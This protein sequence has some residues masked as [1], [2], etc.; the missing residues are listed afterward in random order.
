MSLYLGTRKSEED[1]AYEF[2]LENE[3]TTEEALELGVAVGGN[4]M[5]TLN[6]IIYR[7]TGYHDIEQLWECAKDEFYFNDDIQSY[8]G[9]DEDEDEE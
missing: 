2:I 9:F 3:L 7:Y 5:E 1:L 8:Y 4:N 6:Y